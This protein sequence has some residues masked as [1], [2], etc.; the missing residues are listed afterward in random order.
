MS[1]QI[2]RVGSLSCQVGESPVWHAG[3]QAWY[4][5]DI[6]AKR[7]WRMDHGTGAL[8]S[9]STGEMVACIAVA[10]AG[11]LIAGMETGIFHLAL[12]DG[13]EAAERRLAS[14]EHATGSMRFNDGRCDRQ[15]RFF[16][17]T[18]FLDMAQARPVGRLYRYTKESGLSAPLVDGLITQNGLAWSPDGRTMY[19]SDSHPDRRIIWAFDYDIASGT[20]SNR[21]VLVDMNEHRPGRP[22]GAAMDADGCYWIC[23]NDGS[24]VMRFTPQGKLDRTIPLPMIKPAMCAFGGPQLDT[25]L[26]TSISVN[27]PAGDEWAGAV[28]TLRPGVTGMPE[29][30]FSA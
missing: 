6:P 17:G 2:D 24:A 14:V 8:R 26:V 13:P 4:W 25:L 15:G 28:I 29:T 5:A 18:M 7:V 10:D 22:D 30:P 21:R 20:P 3:E 19:L 11:G 23:A 12:V 27:K 9:W 16:S 1:V